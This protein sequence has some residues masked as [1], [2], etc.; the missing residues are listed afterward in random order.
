[1]VTD[2]DDITFPVGKYSVQSSVY[3]TFAVGSLVMNMPFE[4]LLNPV[5]LA[6][7]LKTPI[8]LFVLVSAQFLSLV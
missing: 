1:M 8:L 7:K 6:I 3:A 2:A 4:S 5:M